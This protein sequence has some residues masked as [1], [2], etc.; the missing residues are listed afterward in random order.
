VNKNGRTTTFVVVF[1]QIQLFQIPK[2]S[3]GLGD[4]SYDIGCDGMGRKEWE[5]RE[6]WKEDGM[7]WDR[8]RWDGMEWEGREGHDGP[9][10]CC[11]VRFKIVMR[12][13]S[14]K[15]AASGESLSLARERKSLSWLCVAGGGRVKEGRKKSSGRRVK[16]GRKE[17]RK[18]SKGRKEGE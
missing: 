15:L 13:R 17:G 18:E 2:L 14:E 4:A 1:V 11:R 9:L 7:E 12:C 8:M 5:G 10:S 3:Q 16:E 6:G